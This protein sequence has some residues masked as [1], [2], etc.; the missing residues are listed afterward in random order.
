MQFLIQNTDWKI[1]ASRRSNSNMELVPQSDQIEWLEADLDDLILYHEEISQCDCFVHLAGRLSVQN[2]DMENLLKVNEQGVGNVVDICLEYSIPRLVYMSSVAALG[3]EEKDII[4]EDS[5]FADAPLVS[6]YARSKYAG[7]Q[8]AFRGRA[9]GLD[10]GIIRPSLI[11][12]SSHWQGGSDGIFP[13]VDKG[14][15]YYPTGG[16]GLVDV[17][18]VCDLVYALIE[19]P[20][21]D[22]DLICNGH[23]AYFKDLQKEIADRIGVKAPDKP[24]TDRGI[25]L[26]S[27]Y[28]K[29]RSF[30]GGGKTVVSSNSLNRAQQIY[31]YD[32]N[33]SGK[34]KRLPYLSLENT[35]TDMAEAYL[36]WKKE[37]TKTKLPFRREF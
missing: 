36:L 30:F 14:F 4:N 35:I 18:D 5:H 28:S 2:N 22:S 24:L 33:R 11:L 13:Q 3:R 21:R 10:V 25:R 1:F 6:D 34:I 12:G 31:F 17:R 29:I 20:D 7:D 19:T 37:G 32:N 8:Q 9:E 23:N 16:T 27:L 15:P 26:I